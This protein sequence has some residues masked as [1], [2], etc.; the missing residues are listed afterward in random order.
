MK[1]VVNVLGISPSDP[2][3]R[4]RFTRGLAGAGARVMELA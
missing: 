1:V 3:Q 4:V 2:E